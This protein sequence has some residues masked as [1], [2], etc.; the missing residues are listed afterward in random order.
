MNDKQ[1]IVKWGNRQYTFKTHKD[2]LCAYNDQIAQ[3]KKLRPSP[4]RD[5]KIATVEWHKD[6]YEETVEWLNE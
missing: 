1:T 5:K 6:N 2:L 3:L 4:S